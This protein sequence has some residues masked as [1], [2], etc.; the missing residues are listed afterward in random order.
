MNLSSQLGWPW[1]CGHWSLV[2]G[3]SGRRGRLTG[4]RLCG[5]R[6]SLITQLQAKSIYW[7]ALLTAHMT[8]RDYHRS[9]ARLCERNT[10]NATKL[11]WPAGQFANHIL[12]HHH[13]HHFICSYNSFIKTWQL[14]THERDR[15]GWLST[16]SGLS[17][18]KTTVARPVYI[19]VDV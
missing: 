17:K 18:E 19:H 5:R 3:W 7:Q 1:H 8:N 11:I 16:H 13:R 9:V 15:Q 10:N 4:C 12:H 6:L 2:S 14:T